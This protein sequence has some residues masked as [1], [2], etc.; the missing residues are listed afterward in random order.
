MQRLQPHRLSAERC[1]LIG[2][3]VMCEREGT[4]E[5]ALSEILFASL[6]LNDTHVCVSA[7]I[8]VSV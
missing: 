5:E 3:K 2:P 8:C 7:I 1:T 6:L 4:C